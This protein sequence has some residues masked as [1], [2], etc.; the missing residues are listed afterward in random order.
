M[1]DGYTL[2]HRIIRYSDGAGYGIHSVVFRGTELVAW[3]PKALVARCYYMEGPPGILD[4][5][6]KV[7]H[8]CACPILEQGSWNE[9]ED[10]YVYVD[11]LQVTVA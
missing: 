11:S 8:A 9:Y 5:L 2:Q 10:P 1:T 3:D 4:H 6:D 7:A